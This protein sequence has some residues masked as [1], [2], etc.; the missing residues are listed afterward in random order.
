MTILAIETSCDETAV[1]L[2]EFKADGTPKK[3][4]A[5]LVSSQI[6]LHAP[7]GGVVPNLA[8]RAHRETLPLLLRRIRLHKFWPKIDFIAVTHGPGLS[9][10]LWQGINTAKALAESQNKKLLAVNHLEGHIYS[11]WPF[12]GSRSQKNFPCLALIVSGGHTELALIKEHLK[13]KILGSTRDDAA[14]EAFD[15]VAKLLGLSYPGGPEIEKFAKKGAACFALPR[16]MLNS[17]NYDFSFS[18]LKTAVRY[19]LEK[20]GKVN[21]QDRADICASFQAAVI[22]ILKH[23]LDKAEKEFQ[24]RTLVMAGGVSAN[25]A[26]RQALSRV[27][28][29]DKGL[30]LDNAL[31]IAMAGFWRAKQGKF[32]KPESLEAKPNLTLGSHRCA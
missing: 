9:P 4:L 23:K 2:V 11:T 25:L 32:V 19:L 30:A 26:L 14:G 17:P 22:D 29:P 12:S 7:F 20:M 15:K 8:A 13:Y 1:A 3:V 27:K 21:H 18:G 31:M 10:C 16:P 6:K 5:N 24:P 28:A